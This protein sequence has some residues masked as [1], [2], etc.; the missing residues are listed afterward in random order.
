VIE[1][2][3][4]TYSFELWSSE[5]RVIVRFYGREEEIEELRK[6]REISRKY[7]RMTIVAGRRRVGKTQLVR[8]AFDD[9][10]TPYLHLVITRKPEKF[11]CKSLQE[12]AER[13]LK[14]L[15]LGEAQ[16]FSQIFETLVKESISHPDTLVLDEFQEFDFVDPGIFGDVAAIWDR[17]HNE[18]H[19]NLVICGSVNRLINKIFFDDSQPLYG[20]NTGKLQLDPFKV[21][22]I[23][24]IFRDFKPNY[25]PQDLLDLWTVTG[26]VARYVEL[27]MENGAFSRKDMLDVIFGRISTFIDEGKTVLSEEFGKEYGT[28]FAILS[29]IASGS[30]TGA[31]I[32]NELGVELG[33]YMLRLEDQYAIV[34]KKQPLF[35]KTTTKACHYQIDDCFFRFWFRFVYRYQSLIELRRYEELKE[36]VSRAIDAFSGYSLERYF[37]WK[38]VED[39]SYVRMGA[40]WDRKGENEIDLV[41]EGLKR[42]GEPPVLDFY[43]IKRDVGKIDLE[44]LKRKS[45]A[46]LARNPEMRTCRIGFGG[47]SMLDM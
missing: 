26:G 3:S 19:L 2:R 29:A 4:E 6:I 17:Y 22:V 24:K 14:V 7:A 41:C 34:S 18:A 44:S 1:F 27:M 10:V 28:Y 13:D 32:R 36:I 45:E 43:E 37:W 39:T 8:Q 35:E 31:E 21:S 16:R 40:W 15:F 20:R 33:G 5:R 25:R 42:D 9:G 11:Q 12:T 23:K 30:T 47:L 46:F 38:F